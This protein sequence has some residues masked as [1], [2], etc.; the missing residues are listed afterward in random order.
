[1]EKTMKDTK[2]IADKIRA[3]VYEVFESG[4]FDKVAEEPRNKA[5]PSTSKPGV[6]PEKGNRNTEG[7]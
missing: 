3:A 6:A 1:M 2:E 4:I 5:Q 7:L